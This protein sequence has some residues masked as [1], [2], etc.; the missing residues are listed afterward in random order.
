MT[1]LE[2]T[3]GN[4]IELKGISKT[5]RGRGTPVQALDNVSFEV[6][7]GS[8]FCILG[9]NGAGK[10]TLLRILTTII[11]PS[12]GTA[13]VC[14]HDIQHDVMQVRQQI[15]IVAQDN[16]FDKYLSLWQNL[17][18]HAQMHGLSKDEY[19][20]RITE[21]LHQVDLYKRRDD[22]TDQFSGGMQRRAVLIRA[23]IHKPSILFLDEPSTGLDPEA[24]RE[25][26]ETIEQFKEW[27]TVILTTHYMEEADA[28]SDEILI[29]NQGKVV[30]RGTPIDLK[31]EIAP[32]NT[33]DVF[34][35]DAKADY[36]YPGLQEKHYPLL[37][38]FSRNH[39]RVTLPDSLSFKEFMHQFDWSDVRQIGETQV[40]MED[41][42]FK[43]AVQNH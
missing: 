6:P 41:V 21:L 38:R 34:F 39:L 40:D 32:K 42:Y 27:A 4:A 1:T 8:V 10:T 3:N 5:F 36:Y 11:K 9:H 19:I 15:G 13:L 14:G 33:F 28:L 22:F 18:L 35:H 24:R 29:L 25:I 37:E 12:S 2:N 16:H 30:M 20:P 26:W 7:K 17:C 23:L 31:E 43:A